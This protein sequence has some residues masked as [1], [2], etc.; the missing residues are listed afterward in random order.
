MAPTATLSLRHAP[1]QLFGGWE[2]GLLGLIG[3]RGPF[4]GAWGIDEQ[5]APGKPGC[6]SAVGLGSTTSRWAAVNALFHAR[7]GDVR[8]RRLAIRSLNYATYFVAQR[9]RISC[10][11]QR[12]H[13][14]Y[15]FSDGYGDYLRSFNWAMAALPELAPKGESH[16]LGSSSV[17]QAVDYGVRRLAYRTFDER[18]VEVFRLDFRPGRVLAGEALLRE[19]A[20]LEAEGYVVRQLGGGDY[21]VRVRHDRAHRVELHRP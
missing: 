8:A 18:S 2:V 1:S 5:R 16:P 7:T 3:G 21:S 4:L 12:R 6:C 13:N 20:D 19:R 10:C 14:T 15:W 11:G 9:G 17:V